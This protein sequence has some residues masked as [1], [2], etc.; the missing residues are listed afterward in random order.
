MHGVPENESH[1]TTKTRWTVGG[2]V[3]KRISGNWLA[4]IDYR[5]AEFGSLNQ[6]FFNNFGP[7]FDD[8]FTANVKVR[9][10]QL[11]FSLAHKF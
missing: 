10:N 4:R 6:K 8:R 2:G 7:S 9:T 5:Y 3:E 1:S 11:S